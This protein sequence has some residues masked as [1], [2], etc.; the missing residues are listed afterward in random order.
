[1]RELI[2]GALTASAPLTAEIPAARWIAGGAVDEPPARPFAVV[3]ITDSPPTP[4]G[5]AQPSVQ[6]W[7]HDDRGS[8]VR[9]DK[10]LKLIR[11]ALESAVPMENTTDR[12]VCV[13]WQGDSPDLTDEGY[14]TNTRN[15]GYT[16]TGRK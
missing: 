5:T 1:M 2:F 3:R 16:L 10:I 13:E 6:I 4:H 8:Y 11:A 9:I 14:N 7:V 12:I 15:S